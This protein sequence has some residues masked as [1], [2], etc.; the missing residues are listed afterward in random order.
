MEAS[1][2]TRATEILLNSIRKLHDQSRAKI[3]VNL[4]V[5]YE[6]GRQLRARALSPP[7]HRTSLLGSV[8]S[9][10]FPPSISVGGRPRLY[11][12]SPS[13]HQREKTCDALSVGYQLIH[14]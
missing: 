12:Q 2:H 13:G 1:K 9:S 5:T 4:G 3:L 14:G 11:R 10:S 7:D 8:W 6:R